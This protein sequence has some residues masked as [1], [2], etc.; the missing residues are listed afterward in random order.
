MVKNLGQLKMYKKILVA[1]LLLGGAVGVYAQSA[2]VG[3]YGQLGIGVE[4]AAPQLK[5]VNTLSGGTNYPYTTNISG[6][7]SFAGVVTAGYNFSL[8]DKFLM[9]IG[10]DYEPIVGS[11]NNYTYSNSSGTVT[12]NS[13][14][15]NSYN[16][17]LSPGYAIDRD[18]LAY[19]KIGYTGLAVNNT[20]NSV[21]PNTSTNYTGLSLGL[22]YKQ[23]IQGGFYGYGE[24][25]YSLYGNQT[26]TSP[27]QDTVTTA[28][29]NV[30]TYNFILGVGYKF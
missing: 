20:N 17:F 4:S 5:S 19:A 14:K 21:T 18:K 3:P 7:T 6:S 22:G 26:N 29:S 28:V 1:A 10:V 16:V 30:N 15:Q 23:I 8:T 9:G 25:N 24:F 12:G 11:S 2:F 27:Y 13:K